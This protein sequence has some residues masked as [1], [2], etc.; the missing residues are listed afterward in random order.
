MSPLIRMHVLSSGSRRKVV[1]DAPSAALQGRREYG[2]QG[3]CSSI[4][5]NRIFQRAVHLF[6]EQYTRMDEAQV[7]GFDKP[8]LVVVARRWWNISRPG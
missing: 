2:P 8:W 5:R 4:N 7:R 1:F 3:V 6:S